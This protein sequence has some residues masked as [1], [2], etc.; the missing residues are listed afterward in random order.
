MP[1]MGCDEE[2]EEPTVVRSAMRSGQSIE[3]DCRWKKRKL[4]VTC[5]IA[6]SELV[7]LCKLNMKSGLDQRAEMVMSRPPDLVAEVVLYTTELGGASLTKLPGWGCMCCESKDS[8]ITGE[9]GKKY[10]FGYDGW[11]QLTEPMGPGEQRRLGFVFLLSEESAEALRKVRK[12][13]LWEGK[14]IGEAVI[15]DARTPEDIR[16]DQP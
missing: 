11:P 10:R 8:F 12:F 14:F 5:R 7:V 16:A 2:P 15:V 6:L 3:D 1:V 9:D 13:Y 4:T